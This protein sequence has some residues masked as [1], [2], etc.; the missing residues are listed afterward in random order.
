[1]A[2]C[3]VPEAEA[4][5]DKE[6][7]VLDKGFVR[8]VD[9]LGGDARIVQAARVSYGEGTK[10]VREDGALIDY[11]LR[12]QH[13][14]PFEQVTL[15]FHAKMPIFVAR[16]WV[17]HRTARINE[18]SG[19]YSI[20]QNEFYIPEAEDIAF[21]SRDNKQGRSTEALSPALQKE[22]TEELTS[23]QEAAY[24]S[25]QKLIDKNIARELARINLPLS[26]YT[27]WYWQIDLHNLFHFL[28]LRC[29][30]H[31]QMEIRAYAEVMLDICRKVAPLATKSFEQHQKGGVR[32]S[33][34][35]M[36]ALRNVLAG[37][38]SGLTGKALERFEEKIKTGK[39]L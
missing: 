11:L 28:H 14:S 26:T 15:T 33:E 3:I 27:E 10:T 18:I 31:A 5:L 23:Q 35:E 22:I 29:D 25:Y 13:T 30:P 7:K 12:H 32:F 1:M 19:R 8:L 20:M 24:Q 38:D 21:Q 4:I 16:Q 39:Q 34:A 36:Q 17:R 6:F 9:Y 2:H 37:K